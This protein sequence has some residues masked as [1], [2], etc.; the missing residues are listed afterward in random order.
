[1]FGLTKR[2]PMVVSWMELPRENADSALGTTNGA[3]LMLS[4][5]PAIIRLVSPDLM[6]R[7]A[8]PMASIP[9]PHRRLTVV[10]GTC[11]GR[12]ASNSDMRATLR[13]SSPAWLAQPKIT[14]STAL[15]STPALRS[16]SALSTTAPR[17]SGRTEDSAPPYLPKGVRTASQ[18]NTGSVMEDLSVAYV[19][20]HSAV[21]AGAV[22]AM[23]AMGAIG[24]PTMRS[25]A[26]RLSP[27]TASISCS[28]CSVH[29]NVAR[30]V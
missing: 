24:R 30:S 7:A 18:M 10:P 26:S 15:Q 16:V 9:E 13:L 22:G 11:S 28:P 17:S 23:G 25:S 12:P 14:S 5:P 8:M 6:A 1:M 20:S 2:Q 4:T 21:V 3:R 19:G 29:A 27:S